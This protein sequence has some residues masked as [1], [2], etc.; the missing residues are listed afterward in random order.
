MPEAFVPG[1][2]VTMVAKVRE[3]RQAIRAAVEPGKC[4][5][6]GLVRMTP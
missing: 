5:W 2:S 4:E 6:A 1:R 3:P